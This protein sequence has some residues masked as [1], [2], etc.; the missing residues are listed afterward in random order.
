M[1]YAE[2]TKVKAADSRAEIERTLQRYGADQFMYGWDQER[3]LVGFRLSGRQIKFLLPMPDKSDVRFTRTPTDKERSAALALSAWE[4]ACRQRWRALC[5]VIKGKLE[6]VESEVEI[7]EE[8]FMGNIVLPN[9]GTVSQFMLPQI[10]AAYE[11][12]A[13]PLMLPDFS[14]EV[15]EV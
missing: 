4:Q 13:M 14:G 11:S 7:F 1:A 9:G 12:G 15:G 3:A 2:K 5:L 8:A 6:S 10:T